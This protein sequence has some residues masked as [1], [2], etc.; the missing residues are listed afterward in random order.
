LDIMVKTSRF[1]FAEVTPPKSLEIG[2]NE[3]ISVPIKIKNLGSHIDSY[4]FKIGSDIDEGFVISPPSAITLNPGEAKYV[5][6]GVATTQKIWDPGTVHT[7]KIEAYSI[8][9]PEKTFA[10]T[11]TITTKGTYVSGVIFFNIVLLMIILAIIIIFFNKI[12]KIF[13]GKICV[14]PDKPGEIK[15]EKE[16]LEELKKTDKKEYNKVME[17]MKDEYK[18]ALLWQKHYISSELK[19]RKDDKIKQK[20]KIAEESKKEKEKRIQ[21]KIKKEKIEKKAELKE[22]KQKVEEE[23]PEIPEKKEEPEVIVDKKTEAERLREQTLLRI[24]QEQERQKR[25]LSKLS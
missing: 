11:L 3:L 23:K 19:K 9:D 1:H 13:F 7:I 4:N 16:Y 21:E 24:K 20:Q 2:P 8:Y 6:V 14:K 12:R 22:E 5:S 10:N 17:I 15:E 18:S 25:K